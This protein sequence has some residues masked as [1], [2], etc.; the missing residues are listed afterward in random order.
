MSTFS[1]LNTA[2]SG[3]AAAKAGIDVVGQN[4]SNVGTDG[5]TRQRL[6]ISSV[7]GASKAGMFSDGV[8]P[9]RGVAITGIARLGDAA[10]DASVRSASAASGYAS[11]RSDA[12]STFE[13]SLNEPGANGLSASLQDFWAAWQA[14]SNQPGDA[15]PAGALLGT[16]ATLS[17]IISTK[18]SR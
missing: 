5:Y 12:I 13:Q 7:P 2:Y 16:A 3:L 10:L 18:S 17:H 14:V 1:G 4:I 8:A 9:G 6:T 15:A 11:V